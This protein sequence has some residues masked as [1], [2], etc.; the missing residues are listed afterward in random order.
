MN[1]VVVYDIVCNRRRG[2]FRKFLKELGIRSQKS[3]FECRL[4]SREVRQIRLYCCENLDL[5]EDAVRIYRV[6]SACMDKALVQ[7]Q[8]ITFSRLDWEVI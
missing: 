2:R 7:G 8:G 1:T 3:V 5:E 6:C 4:D